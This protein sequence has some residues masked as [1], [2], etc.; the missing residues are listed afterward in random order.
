MISF[1]I[2]PLSPYYYI[3]GKEIPCTDDTSTKHYF[4]SFYY[5]YLLKPKFTVLDVLVERMPADNL[6]EIS[7]KEH[8]R[9]A[10]LHSW[11]ITNPRPSQ[12]YLWNII[13]IT[14]FLTICEGSFFWGNIAYAVFS[15]IRLRHPSVYMRQC[16]MRGY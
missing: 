2:S 1:L 12:K 10:L 16:V 14:Q 11:V 5:R 3:C 15:Q 13:I 9:I 7:L 6:S 8:F 4:L